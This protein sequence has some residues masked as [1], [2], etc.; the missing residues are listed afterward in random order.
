MRSITKT[1]R[2]MHS[3]TVHNISSLYTMDSNVGEGELG[4]LHNAAVAFE[5]NKVVYVGP[6]EGAPKS[7][8]MVN[9]EGMVGVPGLVDCHTHT[10][11]A[12]SRADEFGRRLAG[13]TYSEILE[14]G[15][16]ILS[17]VRSTREASEEELTSLARARVTRMLKKGVTTVEI[18]SGY[19]LTPEDEL[20]M[21]KAAKGCSDIVNVKTTFLGAHTTP[22]EFRQNQPAYVDQVV[23]E[24][25]PLAAPYADAIDVFCDK[26]AFTLEEGI[27]ILTAGKNLGLKIKA[28]S[29]QI[30]HTGISKAA[31]QLGAMSVDHLE[32]LTDDDIAAMKAAGTVAVVLPGAQVYL[33]DTSP[34]VERLR[35]AGVPMAVATDL[36]PGSSP[37]HDLWSCATLSCIVQGLTMNEALLGIT[38]HAGVALGDTSLGWL[39]VGSAAD[40]S[41]QLPPPGEEPIMQ[42]LIQHISGHDTPLVVRNGV[43]VV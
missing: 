7:D 25:L 20:K 16:G 27:R 14:Q 41:L 43:R 1:M 18:K 12:G 21:L 29:E 24:Q 22:A 4:L 40:M 32:R 31:S 8:E 36:N 10:V 39:G 5:G 35:A 23:N 37:I 33:K 6:T 26:G 30:I 38:K 42:S 28:H 17:T 19:G 13:A 3:L 11:Y 9:G 2:R 34:P 15:G